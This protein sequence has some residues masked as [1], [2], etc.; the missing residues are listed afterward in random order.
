ME[1]SEYTTVGDLIKAYEQEYIDSRIDSA[2]PQQ[3]WE[4]NKEDIE[5]HNGAVWIYDKW[6]GVLG[7]PMFVDELIAAV[8][9]I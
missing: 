3:W 4:E 1:V 8:K 7:R 9:D 2:V 6:S 5:I